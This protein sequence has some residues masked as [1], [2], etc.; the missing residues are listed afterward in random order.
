MSA[1]GASSQLCAMCMKEGSKACG[2][3]HEMRYCST[4]CQKSDWQIHKMACKSL[5]AFSDANRPHQIGFIYRRAIYF[6][7]DEARPRFIWIRF[8]TYANSNPRLDRS[9]LPLDAQRLST[10]TAILENHIL[11]RRV[12]TNIS[13]VGSFLPVDEV[14]GMTTGQINKSLSALAPGFERH[15]PLIIHGVSKPENSLGRACDVGPMEL[16]HVLDEVHYQHFHALRTQVCNDTNAVEGVVMNCIGDTIIIDGYSA[17]VMVTKFPQSMCNETTEVEIEIAERVGIPLI[18]KKIEPSLIWRD[19]PNLTKL[20]ALHNPLAALLSN[21]DLDAPLRPGMS[22]AEVTVMLNDL[23]LLGSWQVVRKDGK[24]LTT[25]LIKGLH[26]YTLSK[27]TMASDEELYSPDARQ[28]V[29]AK[30]SKAEFD[31]WYATFSIEEGHDST[32]DNSLLPSIS[33]LYPG[34]SSL[35]TSERH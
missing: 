9:F 14:T 27:V 13:V 24:P 11:R 15:G 21:T 18:V 10:F 23:S 2:G 31:T 25:K 22:L 1:D 5:K 29:L 35:L 34:S 8:F 33:D 28:L 26:G 6:P 30:A 7:V 17:P 32:L 12:A 19:R 16:R 4:E 20:P 3:C